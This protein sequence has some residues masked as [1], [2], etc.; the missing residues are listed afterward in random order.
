MEA[1]PTLS[2]SDVAA[3]VATLQALINSR[4]PGGITIQLS[5]GTFPLE[6]DPK[7]SQITYRSSLK[8]FGAGRGLAVLDIYPKAINTFTFYCFATTTANISAEFRDFDV[9]GP[10][11]SLTAFNDGQGHGFEAGF[12][13]C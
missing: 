5:V 1:S 10:T 4:P 13:F 12:L 8:I 7:V 2:I 9:L 11:D 6:F 3:N